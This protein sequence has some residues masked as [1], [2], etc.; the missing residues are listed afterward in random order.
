MA[1]LRDGWISPE[2]KVGE[3]GI[4]VSGPIPG[5]MAPSQPLPDVKK[6]LL[7]PDVEVLVST[8][9]MLQDLQDYGI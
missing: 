2:G 4:P 8:P 9:P 7:L 6:Y 3:P 1:S 5:L